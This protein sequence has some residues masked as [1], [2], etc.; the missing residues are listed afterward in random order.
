MNINEFY[1]KMKNLNFGVF[2]REM[3]S[4]RNAKKPE[5][6]FSRVRLQGNKS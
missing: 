6:Q 3:Y 4:E 2:Y 5:S 1:K